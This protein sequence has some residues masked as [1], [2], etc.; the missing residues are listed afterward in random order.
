MEL[1]PENSRDEKTAARELGVR[2]TRVTP[3]HSDLLQV[4]LHGVRKSNGQI[5]GSGYYAERSRGA[6]RGNNAIIRRLPVIPLRL[7]DF[8]FA[9][10]VLIIHFIPVTYRRPIALQKMSCL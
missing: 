7:K 3:E 4:L 10:N 1:L 6:R 5:H 9:A 2:K 8:G